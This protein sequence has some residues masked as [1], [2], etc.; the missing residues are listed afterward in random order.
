VLNDVIK[1][2]LLDSDMPKSAVSL[3][4][5]IDALDVLFPKLFAET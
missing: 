3:R 4:F 1:L 2:G 5:P